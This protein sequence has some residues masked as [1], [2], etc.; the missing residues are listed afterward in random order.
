MGWLVCFSDENVW[1]TIM[2]TNVKATN[3]PTRAEARHNMPRESRK[4]KNIASKRTYE[5]RRIAAVQRSMDTLLE[6]AQRH[7]ARVA[8]IASQ[9]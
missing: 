9:K 2:K 1:S 7:F 4:G 5:A 8:A 6:R 3:W